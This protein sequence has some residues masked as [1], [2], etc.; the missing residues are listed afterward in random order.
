MIEREG[1]RFILSPGG[2]VRVEG[3]KGCPVNFYTPCITNLDLSMWVSGF[4]CGRNRE[5]WGTLLD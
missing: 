2:Q 5:G 4:L 3:P 1:Y